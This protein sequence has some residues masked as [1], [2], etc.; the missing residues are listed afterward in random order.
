M[1]SRWEIHRVG[2]INFWYYDEE[3]FYFLDGRMLLRGA[4]GSGKSVTMQ[5]FIP[6]LLDGNIRPER[7][8][9]FGSRARKIENYLLEEEDGQEERI[10]YL[11]MEFKRLE[12]DN[13]TTVGI[14]MRARKNKKLDVWYFGITD[15]RRMG[16]D[17]FLYKEKGEKLVLTK[18]ELKNRV[19]EGGKVFDTQKEY[20]QFVNRLLFGFET[21]GE[22]RELLELLIQ[23][24]TPKLS[25]D[26]KP[27]VINDILS[28]SLQ[29]LSEDD[30][31]PMSE[32][33]ENMDG[34]KLNLDLMK[35]SVKAAKQIQKVYNQY[36]QMVLYQK[37]SM[38]MEQLKMREEWEQKGKKVE[39]RIQKCKKELEKEQNHYEE[40][41]REEIVLKK[42][43]QS[44]EQS[45]AL[46]LKEQEKECLAEIDAV[47]KEQSEKEN[48]LV[49]KKERRSQLEQKKKEQI[50]SCEQKWDELET[51]LEQMEEI[52]ETLSFEEFLFMKNDLIKHPEEPYPFEGHA[53]LL[54]T[55][56]SRVE[57]SIIVL[58][59][60]RQVQQKYSQVLEELDK[61]NQ[62]QDQ[63]QRELLQYETL[64]HEIKGEL[65]EK[66]YQWERENRELQIDSAALQ[67]MSRIIEDYSIDKDYTKIKDSIRDNYYETKESLCTKQRELMVCKSEIEEKQRMVEEELKE[68]ETKKDPQPDRSEAVNKNR[69]Y[70]AEHQIPFVPFYEMIDFS[71]HLNPNQAAILEETLMKMGILDAL[72]IDPVYREQIRQLDEGFCDTYLF[73]DISSV[74]NNLNE[75]FDIANEQNDKGFYQSISNVLASIGWN[76]EESST[77]MNERGNYRLG[78]LEGTITKNYEPRY[79][80][81][82]ARERYRREKLEQLAAEK[83]RYQSDCQRVLQE[84]EQLTQRQQLLEMEWNRFPSLEDMKIAAKDFNIKERELTICVRQVKKQQQRLEVQ[85]KEL[86]QIRMQVREVCAK[87]NLP[88]RLDV[89]EEA[90]NNLKQYK[91]ELIQVRLLHTG[92]QNDRKSFAASCE[93]LE[94]IDQD[95]DDILYESGKIAG[96]LKTLQQT[97][98]AIA[99]QLL[100]TDYETIKQRLNNCIERL[101]VI[102]RERERSIQKITSLDYEKKTAE[103]TREQNQIQLQEITINCEWLEKAF[104]SEY[105]LDYIKH[106]WI[107]CE[108]SQEQAQKICERFQGKFGNRKLTDLLGSVQEVYHQNKAGLLEYNLTIRTLFEQL[109]EENTS[110]PVSMKRI[111]ITGKYR[112]ITINLNELTEK[113]EQDVEEQTQLL[114][115]KDRELFEDILANTISKKIRSRIQ[116]S[117]RWVEKMNQLMESMQTSSGLKLS[118]RWKS[119]RADKEEQLDIKELVELLQKDVEIM[120]KEEVERLST[121]FR[122]KI[123][124]ARRAAQDQNMMQSFHMIMREVLDY[125]KWFEFQLECQKT[126]ERKRELTDRVFFT[127]SG[128][129]KAMAMYVPL[130]SA[131]AAK[132]AGARKDAPRLISLDEAFAGVDEMNIKDMFRLMV[133]FEFNFMINSQILWGD[134][135]TVPALAIYQ[136]VR[137]E[138]AKY[139]TVISYIWNGTMRNLVP[140]I[141][142]VYD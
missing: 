139:V 113:L 108:T 76:T 98:E 53:R 27:S 107:A 74:K 32:A 116:A 48:Q 83:E 45:D 55:Y 95:I 25:K 35:E 37:A 88:M 41:E 56:I 46:Y 100:L 7:L 109:E 24:R 30:L 16:K 51:V 79:I 75:V 90:Q 80:G 125:R 123:E 47:K 69:Q 126:G 43:K 3:E 85:K 54:Q 105:A 61:M 135:E 136:L 101:E 71:S 118:L 34:L 26:F 11:Y 141:G 87:V 92:Y 91:E 36:N 99:Q 44:F 13:Y 2:L 131:V 122:S 119:K 49:I 58:K 70:L 78:V 67:T 64:L 68:W 10:G 138:N 111:D 40:L 15:G 22:Y 31:R 134:Y 52:Q 142:E 23:L 77:W 38:Y 33:I 137:P 104:K 110:F 72:V 73:T 50:Q 132:Y 42:E 128:G 96:K 97:K 120:K 84:M 20:A 59:E 5:S 82:Y 63:V 66:L 18:Q 14:G 124:E 57:E 65:T 4:N 93:Y 1:N 62:E 115:E 17:F 19:G 12:S 114:S 21:M 86:E 94:E 129:E 6:L 102:P 106:D 9:P 103:E 133:E 121:H 117:K 130:F 39:S 140:K 8:D 81:V 28:N 60:E 127:F 29:T 112:G 89:F